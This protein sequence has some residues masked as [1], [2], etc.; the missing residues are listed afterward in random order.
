MS[1]PC[2]G[3]NTLEIRATLAA[4]NPVYIWNST[5]TVKLGTFYQNTSYTTIDISAEDVVHIQYGA[6]N[7]NAAGAGDYKIY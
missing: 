6:S 4:S 7:E 3:Y 2:H 1:I 5:K